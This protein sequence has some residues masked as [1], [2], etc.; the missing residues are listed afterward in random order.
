MAAQ[1]I[2]D[3]NR[4]PHEFQIREL[5]ETEYDSEMLIPRGSCITV[6]KFHIPAND[7]DDE[8]TPLCGKVL[9]TAEWY[10]TSLAYYPPGHKD[11]C[12]QCLARV[13]PERANVKWGAS[14]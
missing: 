3:D 1:P 6:H 9:Q 4:E 8:E 11:W 14:D 5:V 2:F 12:R 10:A 13:F 7:E